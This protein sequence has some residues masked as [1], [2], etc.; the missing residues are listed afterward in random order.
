MRVEHGWCGAEWQQQPITERVL[1]ISL[2][3]KGAT[4]MAYFVV[5]MHLMSFWW[6]RR[7]D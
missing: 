4:M 6:S 1:Q 7:G 5:M 2:N 3:V